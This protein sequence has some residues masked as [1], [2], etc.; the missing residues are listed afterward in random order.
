MDGMEDRKKV[1]DPDC[2]MGGPYLDDAMMDFAVNLAQKISRL[3]CSQGYIE[4]PLSTLDSEAD[5]PCAKA[6]G[7]L[8]PYVSRMRSYIHHL[9]QKIKRFEALQRTE[10]P[11]T[12][13]A[14]QYGDELPAHEPD[15]CG[16]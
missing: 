7:A 6:V 1:R 5:K 3:G 14:Q 16:Y 8:G 10:V 12:L 4:V 15:D 11:S 2:P 9:E 13:K